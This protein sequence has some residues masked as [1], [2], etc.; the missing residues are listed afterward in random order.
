MGQV[1]LDTVNPALLLK[2]S[3]RA[4]LNPFA[5]P[6]VATMS[7]LLELMATGAIVTRTNA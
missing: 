3:E 5:C 4:E 6:G 2:Y 7:L 1:N